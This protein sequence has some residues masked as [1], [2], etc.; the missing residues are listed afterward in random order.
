VIVVG[1]NQ[2][3]AFRGCRAGA[4]VRPPGDVDNDENGTVIWV[5]NGPRGSWSQAWP[6]LRRLG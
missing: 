6:G 1:S 2:L 5:C 3:D 4:R